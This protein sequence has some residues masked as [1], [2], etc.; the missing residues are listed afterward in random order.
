MTEMRLKT[1]AGEINIQATA[2]DTVY[3]DTGAINT[4]GFTGLT[5]NGVVY[6]V[7]AHGQRVNGAWEIDKQ[8]NGATRVYLSRADWKGDYTLA[9]KKK[10]VEVLLAAITTWADENPQ[11]FKEAEVKRLNQELVNRKE[12]LN[13]LHEEVEVV[14]AEARD[15]HAELLVAKAA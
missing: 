8:E 14:E 4:E 13:K 9:A 7:S 3:L 11:A 15:I 10:A 6:Y 12:K 5:L 1:K 2:K